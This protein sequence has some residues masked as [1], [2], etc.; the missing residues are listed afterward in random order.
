M[1][2]ARQGAAL[3]ALSQML[4]SEHCRGRTQ[5]P[6]SFSARMSSKKHEGGPLARRRLSRSAACF[7]VLHQDV[8]LRIQSRH[9][10]DAWGGRWMHNH[11]DVDKSPTPSSTTA[12][13]CLCAP[14][15]CVEIPVLNSCCQSVWYGLALA[16]QLED[17]K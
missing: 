8:Y 17:E 10:Q 4:R 6:T 9:L 16:L 5:K 13:I 12:G 2:S 3:E 15:F 7:L 11:K 1:G 14:S